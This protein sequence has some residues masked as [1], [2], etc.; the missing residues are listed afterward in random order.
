M[1][2]FRSTKLFKVLLIA[3]LFSAL[4]LINP[5]SFFNPF[6]SGISTIFSPF[7][8]VLYSFAVGFENSREFISAIGQLKQEN[9]QLVKLNQELLAENVMLRDVKNENALLREQIDLIPREEFDLM[10]SFVIS[11]DPNGMGNWL[12]IDKGSSD[13]VTIGMPV[14][15]SKGILVGRIHEV[16]Q[17][18]SKVIL[19]TNPKNTINVMSLESSAKGVVKGEY[20]LG[21]IF[22]M[23][24]Q[25]DSLQ[26]GNNVVTSGI[27]SD[28]PRG[29]VVGKVQE[30]HQSDDHLFQQA[31]VKAP[32]QISKLQ[33]VFVLKGNK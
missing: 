18:S 10:A 1:Q 16:G 7:Q 28:M 26:V 5:A 4:V 29:L 24:L 14:I 33:M 6:R 30:I 22:D 23:I 32:L 11:Q 12:E 2:R 31:V 19:L 25:T 3:I 15:I 8:K 17:S 9:E 20:G 21:I 13:G 27:G